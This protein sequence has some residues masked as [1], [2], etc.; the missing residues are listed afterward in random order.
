M[1]NYWPGRNEP[2]NQL[3]KDVQVLAK[4]VNDLIMKFQKVY[5][6]DYGDQKY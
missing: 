5:T 3:D 6:K 2:N 1:G 4:D